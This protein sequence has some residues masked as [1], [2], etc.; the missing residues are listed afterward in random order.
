MLGSTVHSA[1]A[2][3]RA[4][5]SIEQAHPQA[6]AG[7]RDLSIWGFA[8]GYFLCYVPYSALTKAL[9]GGRL[10]GVER[11][12]S[13]FEL[14]PA[15]ALASMMGVVAF[16]FVSGWWRHARQARVLGL[17]LPMPGFWTALSGVASALIIATTTLSY[18][19]AGASVVFMALL[20]RGGVLVLAPGV[21]VLSG[22]KVSRASWTAL[23]L[24]LLALGTM[25]SG[26]DFRLGREGTAVLGLY[27]VGYFVRLRV[28]SH[29]AKS[30]DM[31]ATLRYFVEE[32]L[33][34]TPAFLLCLA[35]LA[36]IG[37]GEEMLALR[38]GFGAIWAGPWAMTAWG[39]VIGLMSQGSGLFGGLVL[40]DRREN[41]FCVPVNRASSVL[42]G[43]TAGFGLALFAGQPMPERGELA[44]AVLIVMAIAALAW[45][46]RR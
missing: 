43:V 5:L 28:M 4:V 9:T 25:F 13:G 14:L 17:Q 46:R 42:A 1:Q 45:P 37:Q 15:S 44:G 34:A 36:L 33:V 20:M 24:S 12:M 2:E 8:L 35:G 41:T 3:Q 19:L 39:V 38:R 22:R 31:Q 6:V 40:L 10:P 30:H 18:S 27:L 16:F 32:Q 23:A 11:Q 21:D 29:L 26:A 7:H